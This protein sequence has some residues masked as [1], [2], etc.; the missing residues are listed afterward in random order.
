VQARFVVV[1][2]NDCKGLITRHSQCT[3]HLFVFYDCHNCNDSV[4]WTRRPCNI[5]LKLHFSFIFYNLQLLLV[6]IVFQCIIDGVTFHS[7]CVVVDQCYRAISWFAAE[8]LL[9]SVCF[10]VRVVVLFHLADSVT[11]KEVS[12]CL[13][14]NVEYCFLLLYNQDCVVSAV[15]CC[16]I[17]MNCTHSFLF[18]WFV[19]V[20]LFW[21]SVV[22]AYMYT[23]A[24][25]WL[26]RLPCVY[27]LSFIVL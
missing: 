10:N 21:H 24:E 9:T 2:C 15:L 23:C 7:C 22:I 5:L 27:I 11:L 14:L 18:L 13:I 3:T 4:R 16:Q 20:C 6:N 25:Q 1:S 17:I 26:D 12:A 19:F 8:L